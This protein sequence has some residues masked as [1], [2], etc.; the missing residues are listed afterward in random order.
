MGLYF[1]RILFKSRVK[2]QKTTNQT[3]LAWVGYC[4]TIRRKQKPNSLY[5]CAI[6]NLGFY[7]TN[8]IVLP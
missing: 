2:Y 7:G 6:L 3:P 4:K 5:R 1:F 8:Q